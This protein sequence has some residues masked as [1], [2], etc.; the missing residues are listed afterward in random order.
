MEIILQTI[1]L[2]AGAF[3]AWTDL[4]IRVTRVEDECRRT[5]GRVT[6]LE[7]ASK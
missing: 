1:I 2:L 7:E 3:A 6:R 5:N 4:K